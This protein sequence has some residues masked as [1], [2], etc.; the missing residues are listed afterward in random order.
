MRTLLLI[1]FTAAFLCRCD[2]ASVLYGGL[3]G[4]NNGDSTNDGA[5]SIVNQTTAAVTIVGH[6][7]NVSRISGLVFDSDGSLYATTNPSGGFPPPPGPTGASNLLRLNPLTG[8]T[9]S[10]LTISDGINGISIA[11]LA[12]QPGTGTLLGIRGPNDQLGGQGK[13]YSINKTTGLATLIGDTGDFF[14]SIA[15]APNGTL[16][17][18]AA[19]LDPVSGDLT[20]IGLKR[21]NP[22]N[23]ATL[24]FVGTPDFFGALAVR[25]EDSIIFGDNGDFAQL[26][27]INAVTGAETLIGSTGRN[28]VGDLAFTA[29]PEPGTVALVSAL[30]GLLLLRFQTKLWAIAPLASPWRIGP[31]YNNVRGYSRQRQR[32]RNLYCRL[33][34]FEPGNRLTRSDHC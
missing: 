2:N 8:N 34:G 11:D 10:S 6:P 32:L 25:P 4:H 27:T 33:G 29:V 19:D 18:S 26:F 22:A 13:L 1:L 7:A 20:N 17:M 14:G 3:G 15:F 23:A 16:Y 30:L 5:L 24:S 21:L 28:F 31:H 9:L 12:L